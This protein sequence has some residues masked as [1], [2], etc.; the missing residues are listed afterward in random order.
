MA[1]S[2]LERLQAA[3]L[4]VAALVTHDPVYV[5]ILERLEAELAAIEI[6]GDVV[7]RAKAITARQRAIA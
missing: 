6:N 5:P 7:R 4:K 3:Y 1:K 2:D